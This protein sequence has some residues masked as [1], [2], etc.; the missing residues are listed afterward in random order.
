M[1][2]NIG[3]VMIYPLLRIAQTTLIS[4]QIATVSPSSP[5]S[6]SQYTSGTDFRT[7]ILNSTNFFRT[8]HN[9]TAL[10]WNDSLASYATNYANNCHW[11]HSV[12]ALD[13]SPSFI[14]SAILLFLTLS[15]AGPNGE[16]LAQGFANITSA[17]EAWGGER[18][19]F[20][21]NNPGFSDEAGHFTQLVWKATTTV[22]C[23][24]TY[25]NGTNDVAGW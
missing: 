21:F 22:G 4:T 8:E 5:T 2:W 13:M 6:S 3:V 7:S 24:R 14:V 23:G 20:D 1:R 15:Q 19:S 12:G 16:N 18:S 10:T 17:V 9:A 11:Q 25:C